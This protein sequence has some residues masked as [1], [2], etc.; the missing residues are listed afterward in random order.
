MTHGDEAEG[1]VKDSPEDSGLGDWKKNNALGET[2]T[3]EAIHGGRW[4]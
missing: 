2:G 1:E 4:E 3:R